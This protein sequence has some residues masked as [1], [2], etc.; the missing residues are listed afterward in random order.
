MQIWT[1]YNKKNEI[2][3]FVLIQGFLPLKC[4]LP[5]RLIMC[6]ICKALLKFL[7][8]QIWHL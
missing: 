4:C 3:S 6:N 2:D 1:K 8:Y 5:F 7:P